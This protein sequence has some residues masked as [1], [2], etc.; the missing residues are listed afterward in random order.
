MIISGI[1]GKNDG[2]PVRCT[3]RRD[4]G[5]LRASA[6]STRLYFNSTM[7]NTPAER[8]WEGGRVEK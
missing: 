7:Q 3:H 5:L 4:S 2:P 1:C 6:L 8:E